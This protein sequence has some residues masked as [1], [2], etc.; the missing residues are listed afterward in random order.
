MKN[1]LFGNAEQLRFSLNYNTMHYN[2]N[3][4][5]SLGYRVKSKI[6]ANFRRWTI[7]RLKEYM[8]KGFAMED[9][10]LR[11]ILLAEGLRREV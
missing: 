8:I 10:W 1:Q 7:E 11:D 9:G 4:V 3:I 6:V 5:I 2:L